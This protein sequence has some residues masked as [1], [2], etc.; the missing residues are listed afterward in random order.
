MFLL[1]RDTECGTISV[2]NSYHVISRER[3]LKSDLP[4]SL[5]LK[6]QRGAEFWDLDS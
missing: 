1:L 4:A 6:E 5:L 2:L 3:C